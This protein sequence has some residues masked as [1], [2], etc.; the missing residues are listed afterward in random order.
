MNKKTILLEVI[1][2]ARGKRTSKVELLTKKLVEIDK[3]IEDK[4]ATIEAL[5]ET[6]KQLETELKE[7]KLEELSTLLDSKGWTVDQVVALVE[8]QKGEEQE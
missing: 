4:K 1:I 3:K 5:E 6:K 7:A 8:S 2:M